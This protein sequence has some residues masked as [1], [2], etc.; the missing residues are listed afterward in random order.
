MVTPQCFT[1]RIDLV[2]YS[3]EKNLWKIADFGFSSQSQSNKAV[4]S[5]QGRG[6]PGYRAP[7]LI[8][9]PPIGF[10]HKVDVWAVGC[11]FYELVMDVRLF[12]ED[13]HVLNYHQSPS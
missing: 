5:T 6:T 9:Y 4:S 11:I 1:I 10:T 8:I 2:L 12:G 3:L 13:Y 7:E